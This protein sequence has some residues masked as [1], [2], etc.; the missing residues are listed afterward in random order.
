M[1]NSFG[2]KILIIEDQLIIAADLCVQLSK[3][4]YTIIGVHSSMVNAFRT[5]HKTRPDIVL[6]DIGAKEK[7]DRISGA[8]T[9]MQGHRIPVIVLSVHIDQSTFEQLIELRP[10]AF[11]PTPFGAANLQQGFAF[12]RSRMDAEATAAYTT[13]GFQNYRPAANSVHPEDKHGHSDNW[14]ELDED[15]L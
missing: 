1:P 14:P 10:Y 4:G 5:I 11:I 15:A 2:L 7:T 3:L 8:R 12:A 13:T 6:I 9:L